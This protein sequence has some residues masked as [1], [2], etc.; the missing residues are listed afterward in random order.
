MPAP[1]GDAVNP[2]WHVPNYWDNYAGS[3]S[4]MEYDGRTIKLQAIA[5]NL[6]PSK[7]YTLKLAICNISDN[8]YGSA[9][10]LS[11]LDLGKA[12]GDIG[13]PVTGISVAG[14]DAL[15]L[16][17]EGEPMFLYG[18]R[19]C[20]YPM[21]LT[22]DNVAAS[23]KAIIDINYL[24][25]AGTVFPKSALQDLEGKQLFAVD[26]I[27]LNGPQDT[28]FTYD[29]KVSTEFAGLVNGQYVGMPVSVRGRYT[30]DTDL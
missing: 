9:V 21:K 18:N 2:Q 28:D 26:T 1:L 30:A 5:E 4:I 8:A 12:E 27:H 6:D 23:T 13:G 3:D 7:T 24:T 25:G 20:T 10:F 15:G 16:N 22:F 14:V 17:E 19:P 29:F 11:N